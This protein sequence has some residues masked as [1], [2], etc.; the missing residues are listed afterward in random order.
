ML[1]EIHLHLDLRQ[2]DLSKYFITDDYVHTEKVI[3]KH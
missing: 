3:K 2:S 1:K